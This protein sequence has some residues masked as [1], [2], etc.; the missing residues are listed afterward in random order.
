[1]N[2]ILDLED[3]DEECEPRISLYI[4]SSA[5]R[6]VEEH[7]SLVDAA[8][9]MLYGLIHAR[10]ILTN[11]GMQAMLEKYNLS[12]YGFCPNAFCESQKVSVIPLGSD[13]LR[14]STCKVR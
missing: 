7:R 11:R 1:M 10:F 6:I 13:I 3:E 4:S 5:Q 12:T 9:Q 8:A 14:E 2:V